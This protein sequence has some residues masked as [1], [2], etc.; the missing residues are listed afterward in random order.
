MGKEILVVGAGLAGMT[1]ALKLVEYGAAVTLVSPAYSER[2]Q[3]VMAMGGINAAL[4][5]KQEDDSPEQ[6]FEDTMR[7]GSFINDPEAVENLVRTAPEIIRWLEELG[8]NFTRDEQGRVDLRNFGGQK[9]KRTA[10]AGART[11]KQISTALIAACRKHEA[12]G[13]IR[14]LT[15]WR[16]YYLLLEDKEC[17]GAVIL[18][19]DTNEWQSITADAVIMAVGGPNGVFGQTTGSRLNDGYAAGRLLLQGIELA[20]LEMIQYHPTTVYTASKQMLITEAARGVG[21]RLFVP[22]EGKPWYFMEEWYPEQGALMPRDVVSQSIH[23]VCNELGLGIDGKSYV[24]LDVSHLPRQVIDAQLDEVVSV[25]R[26]YL[27]LDPYKEPI[28]VAPGIHYFMGG[29]KTDKEHRTNIKRLFAAG[30]CS[31]QYHGANRLGGNS[32]LGALCGGFFAAKSAGSADP[33]DHAVANRLGEQGVEAALLDLRQWDQLPRGSQGKFLELRKELSEIMYGS[34]GIY[35][36]ERE[37]LKAKKR[38]EAM[39]EEAGRV[40]HPCRF[41]ETRT[42]DANLLLALAM[43]ESALER[44]ESRGAHQR[45]DFAEKNDGRFKKSSSALYDNKTVNIAFM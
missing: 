41:Y 26:K 15:G 22:K 34:M 1:A 30:E 43:V 17:A 3:S 8:V 44:K 18:R 37:L 12:A 13:A 27:K 42:L 5:T 21:G 28:P 9:K 35:R 45:T 6:H 31:A 10:Y 33:I 7:G 36:K 32:L 39:R 14:R 16:F 2:A 38:L 29:I 4:N 19:E 11:G 24:Y 20:N 40:R 23:K 25:C